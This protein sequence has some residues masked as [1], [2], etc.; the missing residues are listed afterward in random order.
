MGPIDNILALVQ[1]MAW[2]HPGDK[3]LSDWTNDGWFTDP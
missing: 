2:R 1:M 3:P